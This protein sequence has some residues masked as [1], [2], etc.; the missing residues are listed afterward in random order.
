MELLEVHYLANASGE[1]YFALVTD[2]LDSPTEHADG[3][4][5]LVV[6]ARLEIERLNELHGDYF[7][8]LHRARRFNPAEGV[9]MGWERKRGKLEELN[10][11]LRGD[12]TTS[13]TTV[14]GRIPHDVKY[15]LTLDSDTRLPRDAARRLIGKL[16]HPLNRPVW[17]PGADR[18]SRGFGILQ[19][20]VTPSLPMNEASSYFQR[21]FSTPP[22]LDPY[23][24][25]VSDVYQDL[26]GEGSF[27]GKGI[28]DVDAVIAATTGRIP[29]NRILSHD[30]LEGNYARSGLVTD[31]E[32]VEQFPMS[33]EVA[34]ARAHRWARGDWQLLPWIIRRRRGISRLGR[35][36]MLD[37]LRRSLSPIS[38]VAALIVGLALLPPTAALAW[39]V[40]LVATFFG[41]PLLPVF[42][43]L[44]RWRSGI[45]VRSQIHG[46]LDDLARGVVRGLL[47]FT[48]LGHHAWLMADA[49]VRTWFRM[50]WSHR[51]RLEW[52]TAAQVS[53]GTKGTVNH[54]IRLMWGGFV[55]A[56]L[57]VIAGIVGGYWNLAVATLVATIWLA[58]PVVAARVCVP[59]NSAE[60]TA[61]REDVAA[62]RL[63]A[64]R[65]WRYFEEHV[66]FLDHDL[67]PDNFQ[68][69]PA[70]VVAHR[71]SPTNIGLYLLSVVAARDFGW[72]GTSE[73]LERMERTMDSLDALDHLNGHLFNWYDTTTLEPLT[74][75]YISTVD[76]GNLASHLLVAA[77][78]CR[79]WIDT[80]GAHGTPAAGIRD[81]LAL[82]RDSR[83]EQNPRDAALLEELDRLLDDFP[84][85]ES[86]SLDEALV[87]RTRAVVERAIATRPRDDCERGAACGRRPRWP[88]W[89]ASS[90]THSCQSDG[91]AARNERLALLERRMR[92]E[93]LGMD[94]GFLFDQRRG[95]LSVGYQVDE[96]RL[97]E[98]CYDLLASESRVASYVAIAKGDVRTRHW[99]RLGRPVTAVHSDAAL[100]SW[101]GSMFE[102]LMPLLVMRSPAE[103]LLERTA[104]L[105][106]ARQID[107]G[108]Q[109]G[110]PWGI[111]ESAYNARDVELTYQYSQFGVPGLGIV[112]GLADDVV[113]AP[114]ATALAAMVAPGAA[115]ANY[116]ALT[117]LGARGQYGFYEAIDFTASRRSRDDRYALV[118]CYMAHH[119]GMTI[120]GIHNAVLDGLM[121]DRFHTEPMVR[122]AALLLQERAPRDVPT[123]P[124][125]P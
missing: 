68:E 57:A 124:R 84:T 20:R 52:T 117:R 110:V 47:D 10:R 44:L 60:L 85:A 91:I 104:D 61:S 98:S 123:R 93:V 64:R 88:H 81:G 4:T 83:A 9:W 77:N 58:A 43:R 11:L 75:R 32:V 21:A 26:F 53:A 56:V 6:R 35:W 80:P 33:Y 23:A 5:E 38:L 45:T 16:G 70:P 46:F 107:Y 18:P 69:D 122:A 22:G 78:A 36:K 97:D 113:V 121:R 86:A 49:I 40:A 2:W 48:F 55:P 108:D 3:D 37:N 71:T 12:E 119:Q 103:S 74:P 99:F 111:S 31:V 73:A 15:V 42:S 25:A 28:Y 112:R 65:T 82:L 101:S 120:V 39:S 115:A 13:F 17:E 14:E 54:Y 125:Q 7:L 106:V 76:N 29:E 96:E 114:Y 109:L 66:T 94:F 62:L 100:V 118:R 1:I 30:L 89:R 116:R 59:Y 41:P 51:H 102:Y 27:T 87:A 50:A 92:D 105:V 24:F 19:P 79:E 63:V 95:L 72:I 90:A 8:L 34:A 67:P